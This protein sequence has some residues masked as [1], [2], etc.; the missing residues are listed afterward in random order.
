[1]ARISFKRPVKSIDAIISRS[2]FREADGSIRLDFSLDITPEYE[3]ETRPARF[4]LVRRW[5]FGNPN[6]LY[7]A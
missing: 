2:E 3:E 4:R 6:L 5:A 1:M 7:Y